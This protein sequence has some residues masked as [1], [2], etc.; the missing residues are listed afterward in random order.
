MCLRNLPRHERPQRH[1]FR[2]VWISPPTVHRVGSTFSALFDL[3]SLLT[4]HSRAPLKEAVEHH[5]AC[6]LHRRRRYLR[7][8][9]SLLRPC[10]SGLQRVS[11]AVP[12]RQ[13]PSEPLR[14]TLSYGC[15]STVV[16]LNTRL[17]RR[18][19]AASNVPPSKPLRNSFSWLPTPFRLNPILASPPI[20]LLPPGNRPT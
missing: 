6:D 4:A 1:T 11:Q 13:W 20:C 16:S 14:V 18:G 5:L 2:P 12:R 7:N 17:C 15:T 19:L 9:C 10:S 8:S 3:S